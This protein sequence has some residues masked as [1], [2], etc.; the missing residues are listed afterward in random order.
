MP[1][2]TVSIKAQLDEYQR[3]WPNATE[4]MR[5]AEKALEE[6][7]IEADFWKQR[8]EET[9]NDLL[10]ERISCPVDGLPLSDCN[11]FDCSKCV[12]LHA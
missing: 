7:T 11:G 10:R 12:L 9:F 4:R 1:Q 3:T 6:K 8:W 5:T 2:L